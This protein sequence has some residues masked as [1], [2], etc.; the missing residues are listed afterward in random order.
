MPPPCILQDDPGRFERRRYVRLTYHC[1]LLIKCGPCNHDSAW[2]LARAVQYN[3][4]GSR[5]SNVRMTDLQG[6]CNSKISDFPP[7]KIRLMGGKSQ[8]TSGRK[9]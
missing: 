2:P 8:Q 9:L 1:L 3:L 6:I 7:E 4:F 5:A